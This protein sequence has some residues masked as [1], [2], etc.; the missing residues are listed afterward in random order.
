MLQKPGQEIFDVIRYGG[1]RIKI[2]NVH[3][4]NIRGGLLNFQETFIKDGD[5]DILMAMRVYTEG[6]FDGMMM[7]GHVPKIQGDTNSYQGFAV[8]FGYMKALIA[9]GGAVS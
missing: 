2:F 8:A 4:R 1:S 5:V 7:P 9:S 6:G 3:F